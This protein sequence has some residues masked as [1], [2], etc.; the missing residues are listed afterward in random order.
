MLHSLKVYDAPKQ[1]I[2]AY[3]L[4]TACGGECSNNGQRQQ[5]FYS[6]FWVLDSDNTLSPL[7]FV[8]CEMCEQ[9]ITTAK[10]KFQYA[11]RSVCTNVLVA[12]RTTKCANS[13]RIQVKRQEAHI[14]IHIHILSALRKSEISKKYI[15]KLPQSIFH[16]SGVSASNPVSTYLLSCLK[17]THFVTISFLMC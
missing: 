5:H 16:H 15:L 6:L 12:L 7:S 14:S 8:Y 3:M 17:C 11:G 1:N 10:K 4:Q 2:V 13:A 9:A